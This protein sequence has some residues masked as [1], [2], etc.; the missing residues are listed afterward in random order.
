VVLLRHEII[1]LPFPAS[2]TSQ[3]QEIYEL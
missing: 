2:L 1:L 3:L